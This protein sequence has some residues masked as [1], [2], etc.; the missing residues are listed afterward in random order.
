MY[1]IRDKKSGTFALN[2]GDRWSFTPTLEKAM[3]FHDE[4]T[5]SSVAGFRFDRDE[6][7][8]VPLKD[9]KP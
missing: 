1:V 8:V 4:V 9:V 2:S 5:A 3:K 7:E 6:V